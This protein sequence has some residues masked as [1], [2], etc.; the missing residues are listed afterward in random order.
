ME[1]KI[2]APSRV[3]CKVV[4]TAG[5]KYHPVTHNTAWSFPNL[6]QSSRC[7][8]FDSDHLWGSSMFSRHAYFKNGDWKHF[9]LQ[10]DLGDLVSTHYKCQCSQAANAFP[11]SP[12]SLHT[13]SLIAGKA[14]RSRL[15]PMGSS[16]LFSEPP[17]IPSVHSPCY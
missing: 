9:H 7:G 6:A 5:S 4:F 3:E 14:L 13:S 10:D 17:K 8:G 12:A 16:L 2:A 1:Y 11:K 15:Q